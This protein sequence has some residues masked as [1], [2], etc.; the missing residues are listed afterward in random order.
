MTVGAK[1]STWLN[2]A[3]L[4]KAQFKVLFRAVPESQGYP[5]WLMKL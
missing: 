3:L 4:F 5:Q 1:N 2:A